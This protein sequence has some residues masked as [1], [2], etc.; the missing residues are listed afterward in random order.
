MSHEPRPIH[1][2]FAQTT[3]SD[4]LARQPR[5]RYRSPRPSIIAGGITQSQT[6]HRS[7]L[8]FG[9]LPKS[10]GIIGAHPIPS[11]ETCM[12][13]STSRAPILDASSAAKTADT[14]L[15]D[16]CVFL[17]VFLL[18]PLPWLCGGKKRQTRQFHPDCL[19]KARTNNTEN[20]PIIEIIPSLKSSATTWMFPNRENIVPTSCSD[21]PV[22]G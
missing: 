15:H 17:P 22:S 3:S 10:I 6:P 8:S 18:T 21:H 1:R 4:I 9:Y 14:A 16:S 12:R 20:G 7:N 19:H 2:L 5:G 11:L 13:K